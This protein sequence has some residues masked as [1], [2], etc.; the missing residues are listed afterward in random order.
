MWFVAII[1]TIRY[2]FPLISSTAI[3]DVLVIKLHVKYLSIVKLQILDIYQGHPGLSSP[4][5]SNH[6]IKWSY[7]L[8]FFQCMSLGTGKA[9]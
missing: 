3:A 8:K 2:E 4:L 6:K 1:A 9:D 7:N 5:L